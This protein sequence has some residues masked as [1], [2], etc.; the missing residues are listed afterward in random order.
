MVVPLVQ[1]T[2]KGLG[3]GML[4]Y[5]VVRANGRGAI[6]RSH[7]QLVNDNAI[8][9][10]CNLTLYKNQGYLAVFPVKSVPFPKKLGGLQSMSKCNDSLVALNS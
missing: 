1:N 7:I 8:F 6:F 2:L 9:D 3:C 5:V 4:G 10:A